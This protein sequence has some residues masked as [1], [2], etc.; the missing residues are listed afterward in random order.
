[1]RAP[2]WRIEPGQLAFDLQ[3][4]LARRRDDK[5]ERRAGRWQSGSVA[6]QRLGHRGAVGDSLPGAG[7][8]RD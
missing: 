8:G 7:L 4:Q 1:M 6:E 5:G 2:V 3:R